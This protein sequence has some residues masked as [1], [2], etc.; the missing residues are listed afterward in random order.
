[1]RLLP[2]LVLLLI[3]SACTPAPAPAPRTAAAPP[4]P[5]PAAAA[6]LDRVMGKEAPALIALFGP[7]ALDT[8]EG[9]ARKL[10]FRGPACLLDAY[11]YP[12]AGGGAQRVTWVD[13]RTR[14]GSDMDRASCV[15]ALSRAR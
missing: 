11:L 2:P 1:M 6:G 13:A 12:P 10:Q 15:A 7:A 8:R 3:V 5:P 4:P 9:P 14:Q